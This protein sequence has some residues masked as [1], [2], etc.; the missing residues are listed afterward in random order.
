MQG[1]RRIVPPQIVR[2]RDVEPDGE[3]LGEITAGERQDSDAEPIGKRKGFGRAKSTED[4]TSLKGKVAAA[5][6]TN[7]LRRRTT[8]TAETRV[9]KEVAP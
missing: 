1:I 2:S 4:D 6:P 7:Q 3:P 8:R 5:G 9:H